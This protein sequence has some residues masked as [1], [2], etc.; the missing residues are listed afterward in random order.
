MHFICV[1]CHFCDTLPP[2][3]MRLLNLNFPPTYEGRKQFV[4]VARQKRS[5]EIIYH[6]HCIG[7]TKR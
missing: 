6:L 4:N 3:D 7:I 5:S 1:L 2:G